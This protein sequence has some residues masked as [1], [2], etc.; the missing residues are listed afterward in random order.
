[1]YQLDLII[2]LI[3]SDGLAG[4]Y[5]H[6]SATA[7]FGAKQSGKRIISPAVE[8]SMQHVY[9]EVASGVFFRSWVREGAKRTKRTRLKPAVARAFERG[10]RDV[11]RQ[12]GDT[13]KASR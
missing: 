6:I 10:E 13:S 12:L 11:L 7:A 4:M 1:V 2:D 8:K 5:N 3:K 9:D